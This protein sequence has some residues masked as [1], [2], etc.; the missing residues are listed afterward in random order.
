MEQIADGE[1]AGLF[2]RQQDIRTDSSDFNG[3]VA[4]GANLPRKSAEPRQTVEEAVRALTDRDV[5]VLA[6]SAIYSSPAVPPGSGP[7]FVNGVIGVQWAGDASSLLDVLHDVEA[8]FGRTRDARWAPRPLDLDLIAFG[9]SVLPDAETQDRWRN[10]APDRQR[11]ETPEMLILP[12]PRMQDRAFVLKPMADIASGWTHPRTGLT[13][14]Q[15]LENLDSS[16][17]EAVEALE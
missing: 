8:A 10:L 1:G 7:D 11:I 17:V 14:V 16:E 9:Q 12:H 5:A 4:F 3:V 15:H 6:R 2:E 13:V